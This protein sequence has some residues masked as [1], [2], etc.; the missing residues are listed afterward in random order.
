MLGVGAKKKT[1]LDDVFSNYLWRGNSTNNRAINVGVNYASNEGLVWIK[2]RQDTDPHCLFDTIRGAGKRLA[3][4]DNSGQT[5]T[6]VELKSFTSTGYTLGTD[7]T[8]NGNT[9]PFSSWNFKSAPGFFDVVSWTGNGTSGRQIPHSLGSVPG[10]I[11]VR[12]YDGNEDWTC[13]HRSLGNTH[14]VQLNK[15]SAADDDTRFND[16]DPTSTYFTV[17]D[18]GRVNQ[19]GWEYI[20]YVFAGGESTAATAKSVEFDGNTDYLSVADHADFDIGTNWTAE[21]WFKADGFAS[22]S[23]NGIMGQWP[24]TSSGNAWVLEY[25][26]T[27]LRFYLG[28]NSF[29]SLGAA[30]LGQWHHVAISKEGSTTRIFLNGTQ[31]VADYDMG[32]YAKDGAFT[33]GGSIAGGGWFD[34]KI[35]NVRIV[36]GTAVYTSSFRPP[37]E[38]LTNITNTVLLCCNDSS[39]TGSTVTPGTITNYNST[40]STDSPFDDPAAFT[41]GENGDQA[42]IK[43]GSYKGNTTNKP[44][45]YLGF[46]PQFFLTKKTN[47]TADWILLDSMRGLPTADTDKTLAPNSTA[48]EGTGGGDLVDVTPTGVKQKG[49]YDTING[50]GDSY[51]YI[52]IRRP[53][54]Y[55]GKPAE[56]GTDVFA[57]DVGN[58]SSHIPS[59]DS[60]FPV[61]FA[62]L[63]APDSAENTHA[64]AR[65]TG[66]P[67]TAAGIVELLLPT[68]VVNTSVP[69]SAGLPT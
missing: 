69:A 46:E 7:G 59:L 13:Y 12:R 62:L 45:I 37:T 41:F 56:A 29:K 4:N 44:E 17:D 28:D 9:K 18:H 30:P 49:S 6:S 60:G 66:N 40:A 55:V 31:V 1:Y 10:S 36:K 64:I 27:D 33:I 53:D 22:L 48:A 34:G 32:T 57:I 39:Q 20:A 47:G 8:V 42:I 23:Y 11:W 54:G 2:N 21:C 35:S 3:S 14:Y 68:T 65:S 38:P 43:C 58:S 25:V 50:H 63:R 24:G 52:A 16:T 61:D 26:G 15:T 67:L 5:T 19:S 51:V